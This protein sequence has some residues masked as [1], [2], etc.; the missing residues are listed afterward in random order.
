[1]II[2]LRSRDGLERL[3]V[4]DTS[5]LAGLK[6]AIQKKLGVPLDDIRL[7]KD[8]QLVGRAASGIGGRCCRAVDRLPP[9]GACVQ[10]TAKDV[11]GFTDMRTDEATLKQLGVQHG[12]LVGGDVVAAADRRHWHW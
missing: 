6:L 8:L 9:A 3:E 7:S 10:L 1:M 5:T 12:D 2:R 11:A 4:P